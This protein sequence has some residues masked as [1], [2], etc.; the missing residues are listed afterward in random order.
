MPG[1]QADQ[2]EAHGSILMR[3]A[4]I[5]GEVRLP[6][7]RLGENLEGDGATL[8][9]P[10]GVAINLENLEARGGVLLRG[11]EVKGGINLSGARLGGDLNSVSA[12]VTRA[13]G[14]AINADSMAARSDF[15]MHGATVIGEIHLQGAHF[16]GDLDCSGAKL[17]QLDGNALK[18]NRTT[19]DGAFFLRQGASIEGT[20]NLTATTIGAID[21]EYASWPT[22]GNPLLNR[23]LYGSLHRWAGG[24]GKPV[25]LVEPSGSRAL[26][27]G[28]L[29][30]ALRTARHRFL[31]DGA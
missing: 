13:D 5:N 2:L 29:A 20:L 14:V 17:S 30:P 3:G 22:K 28:F 12:K 19:I 23:C 9:W 25:G 10:D 21:D 6:G 4:D 18:L 1:L 11:V 31:G 24:C 27:G 16:G 26:G 8:D 15:A 7:A